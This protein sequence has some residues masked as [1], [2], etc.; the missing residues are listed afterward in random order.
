MAGKTWLKRIVLTV[1]LA[2][3]VYV[4]LFNMV[5]QLPVTRTF[6]NQLRPDKLYVTWES[7]WTLYPFRFHFRNASGNGQ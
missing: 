2:E 5:L 6:V 1:L 4:V 7:A 3:I